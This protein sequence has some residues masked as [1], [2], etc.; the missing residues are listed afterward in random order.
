MSELKW[1]QSK[2]R[3]QKGESGKLGKWLCFEVYY[4]SMASATASKKYRLTCK[5]PGFKNNLGNF[6][7]TSDAKEKAGEIVK[8]WII[9]ANLKEDL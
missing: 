8:R 7:T 2:T 3:Y 9:G 4:D 5:L 1:G 6:E